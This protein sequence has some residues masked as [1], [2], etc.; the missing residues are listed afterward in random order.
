MAARAHHEQPCA[1]VGR[2]GQQR[3]GGRIRGQQAHLSRAGARPLPQSRQLV[4]VVVGPVDH[5]GDEEMSAQALGKPLRNRD[6]RRG[7]C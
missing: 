2:G 3:V 7:R 1:L 5:V 6:G 4:G